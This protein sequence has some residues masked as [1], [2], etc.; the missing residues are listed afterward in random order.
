MALHADAI[1]AQALG[2][3]F[4]HQSANSITLGNSRHGVVVVVKFGVG[5]GLMGCTEGNL[6]EFFTQQVV[7][8]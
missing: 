6:D 4:P 3:Q 8:R 7:K 5:V 1:D 2:F